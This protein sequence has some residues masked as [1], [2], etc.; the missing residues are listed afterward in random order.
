MYSLD[1]ETLVSVLQ[2]RRI[3]GSLE[4]DLA[5]G[6]LSGNLKKGNVRVELQAGKIRAVE[7][8]NTHG[9]RLYTG[10][11]ALNKISRVVFTWQLTEAPPP[12]RAALSNLPPM[13]QSPAMRQPPGPINSSSLSRGVEKLVPKRYRPIPP[14]QMQSLSRT[15]RTVY[16]LVNGTNSVQR[17]ADLLSLPI[18]VVY[19]E[20]LELRSEQ[21][22]VLTRENP[23]S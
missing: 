11:E 19:T 6:G 10:L 9:Q 16:A 7:I 2:Q 12:E 3:T 20:L 22:I 13:Q 8:Q 23:S 17:I 15:G 21:F 4:A 1:I 5:T 14:E 18:S